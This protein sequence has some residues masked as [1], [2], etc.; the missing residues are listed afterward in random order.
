MARMGFLNNPNSVKSGLSTSI[1]ALRFRGNS[2]GLW[3]NSEEKCLVFSQI[4][5]LKQFAVNIHCTNDCFK[6]EVLVYIFFPLWKL[7]LFIE[8]PLWELKLHVRK[9][10]IFCHCSAFNLDRGFSLWCKY[11]ALHS[12]IF[13]STVQVKSVCAI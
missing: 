7:F 9:R 6:I 12:N 13:I 4:G 1:Y 8:W 2:S 5:N 11:D 3:E 10:V